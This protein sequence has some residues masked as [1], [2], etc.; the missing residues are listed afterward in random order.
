MSSVMTVTG[1]VSS[2]DLA[3]VSMHEHLICDLEH[4]VRGLVAGLDD[5]E[6][7][8]QEAARLRAAG[9]AT[10]VDA[11]V[12]GAGRDVHALRRI[13]EE[14]GLNIV[15]STGFYTEPYYPREVYELTVAD[16]ADLMTREIE[17]GIDGTDIRAGII[18][19]LGTRRRHISPAEERVFRAAARAQQRTGVAITT[20]TYAGAELALEQV[21][22]LLDAG[23]AP[24]RIIIGHLGD[25]RTCDYF[26]EIARTGVYV[27]FDHVGMTELQSDTVRAAII[28]DMVE[29]GFQD[30]ILLSCDICYKSHLHAYGGQG[31]DYL[32]V[33]FVPEL[34]SAGVTQQQIDAFLT[35][36]PRR[37]LAGG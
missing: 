29:R 25:R 28:K 37:A 11:T 2:F 34:L 30:Q 5:V 13:A 4:S 14:T 31:Y 18:G 1:P 35:D 7:A 21:R 10:L 3:R 22:L 20:H 15:T 6:L 8:I 32:L 12:R 33:H 9:G 27:Q 26:A 19:E 16:L 23:V 24:D 17:E 36:N